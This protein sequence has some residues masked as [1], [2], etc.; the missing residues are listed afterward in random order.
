MIHEDMVGVMKRGS[1]IVDLAAANGGNCS[2]TKKDEVYVTDN[3]VTCIGYTDI[4]SRLASTSST[5]YANN[6][7]KWILSAGPTTTKTKGEFALDY[8]D[9][10][11]RGMMVMDKGAM[12]WP[13]TPPAPPPPPPK[14]EVVEIVKTEEDY[15]A[16]YMASAKTA[17]Y[18]AAS[19]V[20]VGVLSPNPAFSNM[21]STFC[22]SGV[23]GYQVRMTSADLRPAN[24]LP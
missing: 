6:Q 23:I 7:M 16:E 5:L 9:I 1:V 22:L 19:M 20:G 10:A 14:K 15:K 2:A 18:M 13:W 4:N 24:G 21:F 8:E 17:G 12:T 3:G 11:V